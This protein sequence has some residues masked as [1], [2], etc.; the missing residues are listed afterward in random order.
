MNNLIYVGLIVF[1]VF[2]IV[3]VFIAS[4]KEKQ[5]YTWHEQGDANFYRIMD[6]GKWFAIVQL[7]GEMHHAAQEEYMDTIVE[8]LNDN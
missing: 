2:V 6:D 7:N 5:R 3:L 1:L 8:A 4:F